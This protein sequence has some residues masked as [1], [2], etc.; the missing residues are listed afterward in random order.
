MALRE[1]LRG[2]DTAAVLR[3]VDEHGTDLT[4]RATVEDLLLATE[5]LTDESG[6]L[7][8]RF[9]WRAGYSLHAHGLFE[10]AAEIYARADV[11]AG[12]EVGD[13][14]AL[15]AVEASTAWARG[16]A[17]TS[18]ALADEALGLAHHAGDPAALAFAW[19]AQALVC[20]LEGDRYANNAA[21]QRAL[22]FARAAGD[23]HLQA[24]VLNNLGS[25]A[26]EEARYREAMHHL[27]EAVEI[28]EQIDHPPSE[29]IPRFNLAES[30]LGLGRLDEALVDYRAARDLWQQAGSPMVAIAALGLGDAHRIH[31]DASQAAAAYREAIALGEHHGNAQAVVPA[32]A[33][34]A[35][36]TILDDPDGAQDLV[37]RALRLPAAMGHVQVQL[38]AGWVALCLGKDSTALRFGRMAEAE[39]GRRHDSRSVAEALEMIALAD[40]LVSYAGLLGEAEAIWSATEN[41]IML[42]RNHVIRA[43]LEGNLRAET[44]ARSQLR[45]LGVRDDSFRVA[46]PLMSLGELERAPVTVRTLGPFAVLR[47]GSPVPS[48]AWQSRKA[49][50]LVKLLATRH[51]RG[52]SRAEAV[53]LLWPDST[54]DARN[55]LSVLLTNVRSVLDPEKSG[56]PD[57]YLRSDRDVLG[58]DPDTVTVDAVEFADAARAALE[59][60]AGDRPGALGQLEQAAAMYVGPFLEDDANQPWLEGMRE[61]LRAL[62]LAVRREIARR[63]SGEGRADSAVAWLVGILADDPYDEPVHHQLIRELAAAG[64]HGEARRFHA[65]YRT[66]MAEI[67]TEAADLADIVA[68]PGTHG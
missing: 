51:G 44:A 43:R 68:R 14:A 42:A 38:A 66:R 36:T 25:L 19:V 67:D 40:R 11:E 23:L 56:G 12:R 27:D 32:M 39:A 17:E 52:V 26:N 46:G 15:R 21:Y 29:A 22:G 45:A 47:D 59:A 30:R 10:Q 54:G 16:D 6:R 28:S 20:A 8:V 65:A 2:S 37:D 50:D 33:G 53:E 35:R 48:S 13:V 9:A 5:R 31:G 57:R 49:R 3:F 7:P 18:R 64:R 61:E 63:L 60:S 1:A 62:S 34:L 55:R 24:R 58:L 4:Y 41:P